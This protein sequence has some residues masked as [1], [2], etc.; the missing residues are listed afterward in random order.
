M[1]EFPVYLGAAA[2]RPRLPGSSLPV[3]T[4]LVGESTSDSGYKSSELQSLRNLV[5]R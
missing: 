4:S 1:E 5:S 2:A 3:T